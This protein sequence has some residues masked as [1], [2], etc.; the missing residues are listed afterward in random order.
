MHFSDFCD[1]SMHFIHL[2]ALKLSVKSYLFSEIYIL[3]VLFLLL[4][5]LYCHKFA[6]D[7]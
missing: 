7:L 1:N 4:V 5:D 6:V 2:A 3:T